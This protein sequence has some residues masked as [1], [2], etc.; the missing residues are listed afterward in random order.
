MLLVTLFTS[1]SRTALVDSITKS[2]FPDAASELPIFKKMAQ[3]LFF[4]NL[5]PQAKT[6]KILNTIDDSLLGGKF[7][8]GLF[9]LFYTI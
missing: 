5:P 4:Q 7:F 2:L 9:Q 8:R 6:T 1:Y 3:D